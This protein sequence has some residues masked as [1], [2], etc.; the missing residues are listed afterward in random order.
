MPK[1]WTDEEV[2]AEI[3]AAVSIVREDRF[4]KFVRSKI[5]PADQGNGNGPADPKTPPRGEP[6]ANPADKKK[7]SLWWG[8][9]LDEQ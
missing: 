3:A 4:E 5:G 1:E 8:E 9:E 7:K 2:R 6:A